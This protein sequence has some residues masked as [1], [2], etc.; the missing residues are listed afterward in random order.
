M[1]NIRKAI[2]KTI[3]MIGVMAVILG[4]CGMDSADQRY[5]AA[6]LAAGAIVLAIGMRIT[7]VEARDFYGCDWDEE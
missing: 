3:Q 1:R 7:P 6:I 5:P 2:G 4:A